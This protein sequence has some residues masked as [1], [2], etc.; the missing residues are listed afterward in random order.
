MKK[1]FNMKKVV[2]FLALAALGF[3]S[4]TM[5]QSI[6]CPGLHNPTSFN[7]MS[8]DV[9][10]WTARVGDRIEGSGGSTGSNVLSTCSRPNWPVLRNDANILSATHNSGFDNNRC[11][12]NHCTLFDGHDQRFRIYT[13]ADAGMDLF[14]VNAAGQGMQRIPPG[15]T[16]SIRLGDMRATGQCINS[17]RTTGNNKG[18]EALF[19]TMMV[20]PM[21]ALLFID[22]AIVTCRYDHSPREAGEFLIRVCGKN[23]STGQWNN[24][25]LN[26]DLWFNISAPAVTGTVSAPWVTGFSGSPTSAGSTSCCYC[27]KPWTRVAI[28]LI[29]YLYDSVRVEM[30]TSDCIYD[31]DPIYAYIAGSC[32]PMEIRASGCPQGISDA[33][34]TLK[35]PEG[36]IS[37]TWYVSEDGYEGSTTNSTYM[38]T[39]P[40][41][42]LG[43]TSTSNVHVA[44]TDEFITTMADIS[45]DIQV[46]D[47]VGVTTYKCIMTSAMDPEKPFESTVYTK[48]SNIK[49][50][51]NARFTTYCLDTSVLVMEALG[52]VPYQG[53]D[54]PRIDH[55][56]T[57]WEVHQGSTPDTPL[58]AE[59]FGDTAVFRTNE[60][61]DYAV[62]LTMYLEDSTCYTTKVYTVHIDTPPSTKISI[63][64]RTLCVGDETTIT[65]LT[66]NVSKRVWV[67]ADTTIS[68]E[69]SG[70]SGTA[71]ITRDF[72]DFEN[73][74]MLITTN[75]AD[76]SDTLYDTV[77]FF[78]D[79][80][81]NF[82]QDTIICNGH[83]AHVRASTSVSGCTF[84]WYRHL[85]QAG[86]EPICRGDVLYVRPTQPR[87]TYYLKITAE[88][89]C[90]A[91]DSVRLSLLS[92]RI[93]ASPKHAKHCPGD[94]VLLTGEGALWYEWS[95][96]P[97]DPGLAGQEHNQTIAVSPNEDTRYFLV[98][99]AA[100]S[101]DIAA[102]D[103]LVKKVPLPII[104]FEYTPRYIDMEIP[105]VNL[106][107]NS[108]HSDHSQWLFGDGGV[109][110]G[111][112][113]THHF[114]IYANNCN[115]VT[116]RS[117]NEL[118]CMTDSTWVIAIDTFGFFCPNIFTPDKATN[119]VFS[120]INKS[121]M[122]TFHIS[123]YNRGGALV[124]TSDD[125]H[126]KWDGTRNGK[127]C[128][129]GVYPYVITY[130]REGSL[131]KY[132]LSGSVTLLR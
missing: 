37:Y 31:V 119:N 114:D 29:N 51:I 66:E 130:Q 124:Y 17:T 97:P 48:V 3:C 74:F 109:A 100:D 79:P 7:S 73:P 123:I 67:F 12:C 15:H 11:A 27:Y 120:I 36:L 49:P 2:F 50:V 39:L 92:T 14:T 43:P 71:S 4:I 18:A 20:T 5:A 53:P 16:T 63:S 24:F 60:T 110:S 8:F 102:I 19:Y 9:G 10:S 82:S 13:S 44:R 106:T 65:D 118:G 80:E 72:E 75:A 1:G 76:C 33:V 22:Y 117:F 70:L 90:V 89:G 62:V 86:E 105:I 107:D 35:A 38:N 64:K 87:T 55:S 52:R 113:V 98:G 122:E 129:R 26:D 111:K 101:C 132:R 40:F 128:P 69:V 30:Y 93:V 121:H 85:N 78:H 94:T 131:Q 47:T 125:I 42:Q 116:L 103:I 25:P 126:F 88:A 68:S 34:D 81:I 41:R 99:Y 21:N 61:G 32:Q 56:K 104:D 84:A 46:G 54:A 95:S 77:Y 45:R 108:E 91:W 57:R 59:L 96:Y 6:N 28:S 112:S 83:E 23:S 127:P 58:E 115:E